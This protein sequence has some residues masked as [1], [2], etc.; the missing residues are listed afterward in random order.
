LCLDKTTGDQRAD[1][2]KYDAFHNQDVQG[3]YFVLGR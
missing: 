1:K 2:E 3:G